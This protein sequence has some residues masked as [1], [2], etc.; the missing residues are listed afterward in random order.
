MTDPAPF[1]LTPARLA[2]LRQ[3]AAEGTAD[4]RKRGRT[5]YDCAVA[6]LTRWVW[7]DKK[8]GAH[9]SGEAV[10]ERGYRDIVIIGETLT[11]AGRRLLE[12]AENESARSRHPCS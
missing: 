10:C 12:Q 2:W 4:R 7:A 3:V 8:T 11:D 1:R 6:G 5:G 9:L